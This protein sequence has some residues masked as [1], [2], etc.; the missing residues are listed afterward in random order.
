MQQKLQ[1]VHEAV[2]G[3]ERRLMGQFDLRFQKIELRL[4]ALEFAVRKNSEDIRRN[5][6]DIR[7][8]SEDIRELREQVARLNGMLRTDSD[9]NAIAM[10][11]RRIE[12]LEQRIG[13]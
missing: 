5:S 8:N 9:E 7:K 13:T 2:Q 4:D 12:A 6:E 1:A 11:E 10:L 3:A